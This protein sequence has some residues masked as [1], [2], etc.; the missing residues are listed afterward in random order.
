MPVTT[1]DSCHKKSPHWALGYVKATADGA[2]LKAI[3]KYRR[4]TQTK[5]EQCADWGYLL[6]P[7][8]EIDNRLAR[9][10]Q[11]YRRPRVIRSWPESGAK[12]ALVASHVRTEQLRGEFT[13]LA[14]QWRRETQHL[15][16]ISKKVTSE[17]YLRIVGMGPPVVP[18]LLEALRDRP[19]YWFAALKSTANVDPVPAG[20]SPLEAREEWLSWGKT[21]GLIK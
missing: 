2:D 13:A 9:V 5:R 1:S 6:R 11:W 7:R 18:L 21:K 4:E 10:F 3:L 17:A 8:Y 14:E 12:K 15:S 20:A 16:Q 19:A